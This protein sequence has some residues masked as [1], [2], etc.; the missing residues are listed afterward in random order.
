MSAELFEMPPAE[1]LPLSSI[2][3][4]RLESAGCGENE[5]NACERIAD[6]R[7]PLLIEFFCHACPDSWLKLRLMVSLMRWRIQQR[8]FRPVGGDIITNAAKFHFAACEGNNDP[9][10]LYTRALAI[11]C[12]EFQRRGLLSMEE[13]SKAQV[14]FECGWVA[15]SSVDW[16]SVPAWIPGG[17]LL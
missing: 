14:L 7:Q 11:V 16:Q 3:L 2:D 13:D 10:L 15:P 8:D 1:P 5:I 4:A 6:D 9:R 12:P 17:P